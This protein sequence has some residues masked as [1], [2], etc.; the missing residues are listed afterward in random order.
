VWFAGNHA[1][2]RRKFLKPPS[3]SSIRIDMPTGG[4]IGP[5]KVAVLEQI[6]RTGSISAAGRELKM[7]YRQTWDLIEDL[8][9]GLGAPLSKRQSAAAQAVALH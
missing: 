5:G 7:S 6:A 4:R 9:R 1:E 8:N 3:A 2:A